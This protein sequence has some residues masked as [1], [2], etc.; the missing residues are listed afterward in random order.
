[1]PE[2]FELIAKTMFGLE[3]VLAAE[4]RALG[5][6]GIE[7]LNRA[8]KFTADRTLMYKCNLHLR[9]AI[10]ILKPIASFY[11]HHE[12]QLYKRVRQIDWE[13]YFSKDQTFAIG[14]T[15]NSEI[16]RHSKFAALKTK[17]AIVDQF[18]SKYGVRP[19][20]DIRNPD[21]VINIHIADKLVTLSL[22]SSGESLDRRGYRLS[23]TE[24]PLNEVLAAG[25]LSLA[26]WQGQQEFLDPMCGS[27]TFAIE[28]ALMAANMAPGRLRR[29]AFENWRDFD[30]TRWHQLK[31]EAQA[32]V[33]SFFGKINARDVDAGALEFAAQNARRAGVSE[34]ITF[35]REDFLQTNQGLE[36]GFIVINPPYGERL[37]DNELVSFYKNIGDRLKHDFNGCEAWIISSNLEVLKFI[38]LRPSRKIK[39]YNGALECRL[40]KYELYRGSKKDRNDPK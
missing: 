9:T 3:E 35:E 37:K 18:R 13:E 40:Q 14:S 34:M 25:I 31:T 6:Q 1:M 28:A 17:D 11:A 36:N 39:L 38:G 26:G 12:N 7:S 32:Q 5:A 24:A 23:T 4:L 20:V 33:Q 29:F 2:T 19:S 22:D 10:S 27:G 15:T 30:A 8:V 16:F 21:F